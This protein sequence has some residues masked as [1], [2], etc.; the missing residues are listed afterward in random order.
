MIKVITSIVPENGMDFEEICSFK[1]D[2]YI[3]IWNHRESS[4]FL[5]SESDIEF[6]GISIPNC[7]TLADLDNAVYDVCD[8][9][10][11]EVSESQS[12]H[13]VLIENEL[14]DE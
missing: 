4:W 13:F 8:E 11:I 10:I 9:H 14:D 1:T 6:N 3:G 5:F 7:E 12:Y 2:N